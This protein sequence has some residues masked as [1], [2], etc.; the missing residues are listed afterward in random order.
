MK[1]AENINELTQYNRPGHHWIVVTLE[2]E[3][4]MLNTTEEEAL[5]QK[6]IREGDRGIIAVYSTDLVP[7]ALYAPD[8]ISRV[9][10]DEILNQRKVEVTIN[11]YKKLKQK[12][13]DLNEN[14]NQYCIYL[15]S[16]QKWFRSD[17]KK[18]IKA[19]NYQGLIIAIRVISTNGE[20]LFEMTHPLLKSRSQHADIVNSFGGL[21]SALAGGEVLA[22]NVGFLGDVF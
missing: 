4:V 18:L 9:R 2:P 12:L 6:L 17:Y 10:L 3:G 8:S 14:S 16:H 7:I 13:F 21:L 20:V 11:N 5:I 19:I 22:A 15:P 1:R